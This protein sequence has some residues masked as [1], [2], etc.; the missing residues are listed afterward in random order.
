MRKMSS[1]TRDTYAVRVNATNYDGTSA[2]VSADPVK[3]A[4]MPKGQK[5]AVTDWHTG[6]WLAAGVAGLLIGAGTSVVLA[7]GSY[8]VW[9]DVT[10]TTEEPKE[11][12]DVL[13]IF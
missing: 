1:L 6:S 8:D 5:P 12:V 9:I 4:F 7:I 11:P 3:L 10:D 13:I 2:D